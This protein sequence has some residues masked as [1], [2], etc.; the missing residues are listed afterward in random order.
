MNKTTVSCYTPVSGGISIP[1]DLK[2][3]LGGKSQPDI[4]TACTMV[5]PAIDL[6]KEGLAVQGSYFGGQ[7]ENHAE[8]H[9][10]SAGALK[11]LR[12]ILKAWPPL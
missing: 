2:V 9:E 6:F 10:K 7:E 12:D 3:D 5:Q 8:W 11:L 4:A 1:N